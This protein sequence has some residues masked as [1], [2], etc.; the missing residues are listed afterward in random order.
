MTKLQKEL[1]NIEAGNIAN[2]VQAKA[3]YLELLISVI[4]QMDETSQELHYKS[5]DDL[6]EIINALSS[7]QGCTPA[8]LVDGCVNGW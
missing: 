3:S 4:N 8:E 5:V 1:A 2:S 6:E 7:E